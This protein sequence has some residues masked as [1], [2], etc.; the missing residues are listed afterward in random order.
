MDHS[1][2]AEHP[3]GD[4]RADRGPAPPRFRS[5]S[6]SPPRSPAGAPPQASW[7]AR[8]RRPRAIAGAS[9]WEG[10]SPTVRSW[11]GGSRR[12]PAA[13]NARQERRWRSGPERDDAR[14][15]R[16]ES[17]RE[18]GEVH[19]D[20]RRHDPATR[21]V[22]EREPC[23]CEPHSLPV[24]VSGGSPALAKREVGRPS[25]CSPSPGSLPPPGG[26]NH[27]LRAPPGISS[28]SPVSPARRRSPPN[29]P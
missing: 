17:R 1:L 21:Q 4:G 22:E 28:V 13:R 9:R 5:A 23:Q 26:E 8:G 14:R 27:A 10:R 11:G 18:A 7:E 16:H 19:L 12:S 2:P 29:E 6:R 25:R 24:G 20:R 15:A 3:R